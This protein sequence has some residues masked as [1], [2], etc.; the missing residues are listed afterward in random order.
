MVIS[1][2]EK[3]IGTGEVVDGEEDEF[4]PKRFENAKLQLTAVI[5]ALVEMKQ[6]IDTSNDAKVG[7]NFQ[8]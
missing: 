3:G 8:N 6:E 5:D 7:A 2:L 4:I 1:A